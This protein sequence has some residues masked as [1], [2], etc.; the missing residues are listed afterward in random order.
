[1]HSF[2]SSLID[3]GMATE[4]IISI[5]LFFNTTKPSSVL[6]HFASINLFDLPLFIERYRIVLYHHYY[7]HLILLV[8]YQ[9]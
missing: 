3:Y 7:F 6:L 5:I 8:F 9:L 1:M 2:L 4:S